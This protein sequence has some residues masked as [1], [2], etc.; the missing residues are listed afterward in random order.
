VTILVSSRVPSSTALV[1][2]LIA[3]PLITRGS[4]GLIGSGWLMAECRP[5]LLGFL[6]HVS[7]R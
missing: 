5:V 7:R 2:L 3:A 6:L 4:P 1:P